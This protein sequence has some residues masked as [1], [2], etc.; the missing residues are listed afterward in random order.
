MLPLRIFF[1]IS[2]F[3]FQAGGVLA[4][5]T[6]KVGFGEQKTKSKK[7]RLFI[8]GNSFSQNASKFLPQL[9]KEKGH[10]LLIGRA[11]LGG[12]SL[13]RHWEIVEAYEANPQDPK[14]RQYAG[15]SLKMLLSEGEWD[16]VTIQQNSLNTTFLETFQPYA[17]NLYNYIKKL[18][19][20]AEV[21]L[22]Q[23]WAYRTDAK[24]FG[25][26]NKTDRA[27]TEKEM[28]E[29]SRANYHTIAQELG[30]RLFPVGDAFW[31]VSSSGKWAYRPENLA[32]D[33]AKPVKPNLPNQKN[34]LHV[35]YL[36]Q[37]KN[38]NFDPNHANQAGEYLG[39]LI[40]YSV[41]F[42]ESPSSLDFVPQEVPA[43]FA[44]YL[45][46]V[47]KKEVQKSKNYSYKPNTAA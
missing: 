19:P 12:C 20:N 40:W 46:K 34:S 14:G 44:K 6:A 15:K 5:P 3:I 8:I 41:L 47:A 32:Y 23:T 11:E 28:W 36:W 21:I 1:F 10:D 42:N 16:V 13:Q 31:Q 27:K 33:F 7:V 30:V 9:A 35:G 29:K 43:D 4:L 25:F 2:V 26:V 45:R 18:Q 22:H 17:T 37:G 24:G 39:S 38:L